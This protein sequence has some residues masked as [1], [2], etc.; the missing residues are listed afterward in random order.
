MIKMSVLYLFV[1]VLHLT[2]WEVS[3]VW[4]NA[5]DCKSIPSGS[6]VRILY[7]PPLMGY[8]QVVRQWFLVPC[9]VGSNPTTPA[10]FKYHDSAS[11]LSWYFLL[12][13]VF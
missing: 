13:I 11:V 1:D 2:S 5:V 6:K 4:S 8:S 12:L 10:N 3:E 9:S 7:L